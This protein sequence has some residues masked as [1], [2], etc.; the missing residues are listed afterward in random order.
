[1]I[2]ELDDRLEYARASTARDPD[3][4]LS[5]ARKRSRQQRLALDHAPEV[6]PARAIP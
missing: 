5:A 2:E 3:E 1:L 6:A 4:R